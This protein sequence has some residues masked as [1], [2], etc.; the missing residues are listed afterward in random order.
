MNFNFYIIGTP[1][2]RYNQYPD[3]YI[4]SVLSNLRNNLLGSRLVI[5]REMNLMHYVYYERIDKIN[6]IG[7]CLVFNN[8]RITRPQSFISL[9]KRVIEEDLVSSGKIIHYDAQGVLGYVVKSF[10][11]NINEYKKIKRIF[12]EELDCSSEKYGI[13]PLE[14][15]YNGTKTIGVSSEG[16]T[17][18][19]IMELTQQHNIVFINSKKGIEVGYIDKIISQLRENYIDA[20]KKIEELEGKIA[21]VNR[22]KKQ[23]G[24]VAILSVAIIV[25]LVG[26]YSLKS[27]LTGVI[28]NQTTE[29]STLRESNIS[30]QKKLSI[31]RDSIGI[32]L[33]DIIAKEAAISSLNLA[34]SHHKDSLSQCI[35]I[36][37]QLETNVQTEK[38]KLIRKE[39]ELSDAKESLR[40]AN[41]RYNSFRSSYP[42]QITKIDIGNVDKYGNIETD[43]G[44]TIYSRNT[45][46]LKPRMQY[47][48]INSGQSIELK[49][50]WFYNNTLSTG[51]NSPAGF[52]QQ[53]AISVKSGT[54]TI[55]LSGWGNDKKRT[56]KSGTYRI[57]IWYED[58]CLKAKA[59][60][61]Y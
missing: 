44:G 40:I 50:K 9:C 18:S 26:I 31:I 30:Q 5:T 20:E 16:V 35:A 10:S 41:S 22:K 59:F 45:M 55:T 57:E 7:F 51:N 34:L 4:A 23:Y 3:D 13:E 24:W 54:N 49:V 42:I 43:Y 52:S 48:G 21:K 28:S 29:I 37:S 36:I 33:E 61:I 32:L 47:V 8:V 19:Q 17:D 11:D 25:C 60:T 46:Y 15:I 58:V 38:S 6:F 53:K 56:W 2:G 1:N 27:N 14:S 39:K 12:E